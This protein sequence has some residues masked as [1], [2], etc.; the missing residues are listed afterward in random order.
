MNS[1][2]LWMLRASIC[3]WS[4][5]A[6]YAKLMRGLIWFLCQSSLLSVCCSP[7]SFNP[8]RFDIWNWAFSKIYFFRKVLKKII[9]LSLQEHLAPTVVTGSVRTIRRVD[10]GTAIDVVEH[11]HSALTHTHSTPQRTHKLSQQIRTHYRSRRVSGSSLFS[12]FLLITYVYW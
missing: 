7:F 5:G 10:D 8:N 6:T 3:R 4:F 12:K 11:T 9:F 2:L 1:P